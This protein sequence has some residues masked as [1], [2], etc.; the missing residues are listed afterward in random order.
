MFR[1]QILEHCITTLAKYYQ[2]VNG[3]FVDAD[4]DKVKKVL[5]E[6]AYI[7]MPDQR[8]FNFFNPRTFRFG[9]R[10]SF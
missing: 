3:S 4:S 8:F 7:N 6:K 10:F 5:D 2:Y 9:I 1:T